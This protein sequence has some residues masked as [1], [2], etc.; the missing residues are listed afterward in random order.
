MLSKNER[1]TCA[2]KA[3]KAEKD[4]NCKADVDSLRTFL[5]TAFSDLTKEEVEDLVDYSLDIINGLLP[6]PGHNDEEMS[7]MNRR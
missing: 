6:A 7:E 1:D 2:R 5:C 3:Y 4:G